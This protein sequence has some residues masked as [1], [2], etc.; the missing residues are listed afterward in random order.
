MD[1]GIDDSTGYIRT[2]FSKIRQK[3]LGVSADQMHDGIKTILKRD[4]ILEMLEKRIYQII[5]GL[6]GKEIIVSGNVAESE[7][8]EVCFKHTIYMKSI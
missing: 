5:T 2:S 4:S 8:V 3:I 1:L 7:Y 6:L